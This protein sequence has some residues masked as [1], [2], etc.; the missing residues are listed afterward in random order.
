MRQGCCISP[1]LFNLYGEW[2]ANEALEGVGDFM[3]GGR[4]INTIKYADDL[5]LLAKNEETL[6]AMMDRMVETGKNYGMDI[7]IDK[8]KVMRISKR[9]KPLR[10][11][12]ELENVVQFKYLGSLVTN[13]AY[14]TNEIRSRIAMAKAAFNKKITLLTSK[15]SLELRKKLVMCYIW[16][17]ALYGSETWTLRKKEKKYLESFEMWCWRRIAKIKWT[18]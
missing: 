16:S 13:D 6:Q 9:D 5:V 14:C 17:I 15:L 1:I 2:L 7:N 11:N 4:V 3:I 8:S 12:Q 18:D 10:I